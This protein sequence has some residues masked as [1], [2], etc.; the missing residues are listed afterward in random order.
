MERCPKLISDNSDQVSLLVA[1]LSLEKTEPELGSTP[2]R[3]RRLYGLEFLSS[4]PHDGIRDQ[5]VRMDKDE[6]VLLMEAPSASLQSE[7]MLEVVLD[8]EAV[9][10]PLVSSDTSGCWVISSRS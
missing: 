6:D 10:T 9:A 4:S 5:T 3:Q 8:G 2:R 1:L 7:M